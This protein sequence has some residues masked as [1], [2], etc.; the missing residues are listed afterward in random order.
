M[1]KK[2]LIVDDEPASLR[3]LRYFLGQEGYETEGAK[4]AVEALQ[5]LAQS[6]FDLAFRR[7]NA[8]S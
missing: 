7:E 6:R 5:L 1:G 4:D 2:I 8:S 3:V